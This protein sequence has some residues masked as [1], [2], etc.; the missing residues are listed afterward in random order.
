M[1]QHITTGMAPWQ[2]RL[3]TVLA[4]SRAVTPSIMYRTLPST[5]GPLRRSPMLVP[6]LAAILLLGGL[7][8]A[9]AV[10]IAPTNAGQANASP[11]ISAADGNLHLPLE[12]TKIPA[13]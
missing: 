5:P 6:C 3:G 8:Y 7:V 2:D 11:L 4:R 1:S 10:S 9:C 12:G 13:N